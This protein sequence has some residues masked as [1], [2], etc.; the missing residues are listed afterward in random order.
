MPNGP[1]A[2]TYNCTII[3]TRPKP[4]YNLLLNAISQL[5]Q[6][7]AGQRTNAEIKNRRIHNGEE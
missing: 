7:S 1:V 3:D 2:E 6:Y 4:D 5:Q